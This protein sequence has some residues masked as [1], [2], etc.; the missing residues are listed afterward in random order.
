MTCRTSIFD[1]MDVGVLRARLATLQQAYLDL[2][3]GGK[4]VSVSYTQGDGAR[5][6][7][8]SQANIADLTQAILALQTQIDQLSGLRI[9][10][11]APMRPVF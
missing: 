8:Y 3:A 5:S 9:N 11:R 1:G 4:I 7:T 2:M 10:R 6:V